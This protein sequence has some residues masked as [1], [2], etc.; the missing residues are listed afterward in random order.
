LSLNHQ[1]YSQPPQPSS[2]SNMVPTQVPTKR[3]LTRGPVKLAEPTAS[4]TSVPSA[5]PTFMT[6]PSPRPDFV[7][8]RT[9]V[10]PTPVN[11]ATPEP[12]SSRNY[13]TSSSSPSFH[14]GLRTLSSTPA[15]PSRVVTTPAPSVVVT[16]IVVAVSPVESST[17]ASTTGT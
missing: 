11:Y 7:T 5:Y 12:P 2:P 16:A 17:N 1:N 6:P 3:P 14:P 4:P 9:T 8:S 15:P 13:T 10:G